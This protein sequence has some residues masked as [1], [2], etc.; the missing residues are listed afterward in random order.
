MSDLQDRVGFE[1]SDSS[2]GAMTR[3]LSRAEKTL[4]EY[5][6][7]CLNAQDS[8]AFFNALA[9][10]PDFNDTLSAALEEHDRRVTSR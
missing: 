4:H 10:P 7:M 2:D 5:E 6:R 1:G 9:S 8:E 3:R